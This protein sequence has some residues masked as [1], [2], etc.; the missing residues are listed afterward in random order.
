MPV[1]GKS[2]GRFVLIQNAKIKQS[3]RNREEEQQ[4]MA[5]RNS[6]FN[7]EGGHG[8]GGKGVGDTFEMPKMPNDKTTVPNIR[9]RE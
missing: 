3:S 8:R 2:L 9:K 5:E 6:F 1:N 7:R 4:R